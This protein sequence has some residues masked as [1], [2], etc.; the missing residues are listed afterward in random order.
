MIG[1]AFERYFIKAFKQA[2]PLLRDEALNQDAELFCHQEA[3]HL[4]E[5][6]GVDMVNYYP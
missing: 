2:I 5:E 1:P 3:Q 6:Q 4:D